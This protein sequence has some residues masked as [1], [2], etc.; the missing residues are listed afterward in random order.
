MA[1]SVLT[2]SKWV[3]TV[4]VTSAQTVVQHI[5]RRWAVPIHAQ[6]R[7]TVRR[8]PTKK[9]KAK[10]KTTKIT[11]SYIFS[12]KQLKQA[13]GME[14]DIKHIELWAGTAPCDEGKVGIHDKET[15]NIVTE[16]I[17]DSLKDGEK[18]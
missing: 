13:L 2:T 15:Y 12:Q 18:R 9:G 16:E 14:G 8:M 10:P 7:W 11:R 17:P 5:A 1:L 3:V 4:I 6:K